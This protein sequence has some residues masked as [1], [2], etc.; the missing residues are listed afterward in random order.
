MKAIHCKKEKIHFKRFQCQVCYENFTNKSNLNKHDKTMHA[1]F[2]LYKCLVCKQDYSTEVNV[3]SHLSFHK[4][5]E[6]IQLKNCYVKVEAMKCEFCFC[7][8]SCRDS[9]QQH[10]VRHLLANVRKN[11]IKKIP[12]VSKMEQLFSFCINKRNLKAMEMQNSLPQ[13]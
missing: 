3:I 2:T 10:I 12:K 9:L 6:L 4:P 7:Y 13:K 11:K 1:N 5:A 8:F